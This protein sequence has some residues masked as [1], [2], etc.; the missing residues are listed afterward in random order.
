MTD[1]VSPRERP[2]GFAV[3][4]Q[5]WSRLIFLHW[6]VRPEHVRPLIPLPLELDTFDQE[7]WVGLVAFTVTRMRPAL[8]PPIP[9]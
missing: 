1:R 4:H 6:R 2:S 3:L 8:I 9:G 7:A 5:R